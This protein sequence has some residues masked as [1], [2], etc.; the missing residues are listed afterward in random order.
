MERHKKKIGFFSFNPENEEA[1]FGLDIFNILKSERA[2]LINEITRKTG[3]SDEVVAKYF[4]SWVKK[5]ML[6]I[7]GTEK[8]GLVKFNEENKTV[9]G[10][11]FS[12]DECILAAMDL[13]GNIKTKEKISIDPLMKLKGRNREIKV[14]L[15]VI[16]EQT[17]LRQEEFCCAGIAVPERVAEII[18]K[19]RDL[20][21]EGVSR[22]FGS[23]VLV[24]KEATA[25]G[26]S[27]RDYGEDI[28]GR[29]VLYMHSDVGS[30]A[31]IKGEMI[32]EP[33]TGPGSDEKAYLRPWNQFSIVRVAKDLVNKGVG[34]DIVNMVN[35]D[36]ESITLEVVMDAAGNHDELAED[37]V[38]RS[39]LALGVRT[40]YLV[41]MFNPEVVIL[42]GG[43][44]KKEGDFAR[45]VK[46]SAEKFFL[47]D[48]TGKMDIIPGA[49]G[50]EASSVGAA[51]LCR[52]EL[53]MEV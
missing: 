3:I 47:D 13:G 22:I 1:Q 39:G 37:L 31:V 5:D 35:G 15:E 50:K 32:F 24:T 14:I 45:F 36:I 28:R 42:G 18:P 12:N 53:F 7:S 51:L 17:G 49:L 30:G 33:D 16:G 2:P 40:A 44:E 34:T 4:D 19:S 6:K 11:G 8:G 25:A 38:K 43:T 10:I 26:Y 52:R 27:E 20:L 46:E 41:N 48:I 23:D 29:D 21:A 9:L